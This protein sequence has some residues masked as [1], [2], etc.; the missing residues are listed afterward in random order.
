MTINIAA[1]E[2]LLAAHPLQSRD[3]SRSLADLEFWCANKTLHNKV[4]EYWNEGCCLTHAVGLPRHPATG[5]EMP[6]TDYQMDFFNHIASG[7]EGGEIDQP[8]KYH[9]NKARQMGFTEIV[10][11]TIQYGCINWY[12]GRNVGIVAATNGDLARK[13]MRR[14]TRLFRNIPW[15]VNKVVYSRTVD[16]ANGT[17]VEAFPASEEAMTGD[18]NYGAIFMDEAAKWRLVN[19]EPV[20]NSILPIVNTSASDLFLVSTPKGPSKMFYEIHKNPKDFK[21][22]KY[23][24]WESEGQLYDRK[25]IQ[26]MI[27]M[28]RESPDQE[29]LCRFVV[30]SDAAF[31]P[32][33]DDMRDDTGEWLGGSEDDHYVEPNEE[34][35]R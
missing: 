20:F 7:H 31:A 5:K 30:G 26:Y 27:K 13:D 17:R 32:V 12:T 10:L 35:S 19:D 8:H 24:I 21:K 6:L 11:R 15:M 3:G 4:E 18:T 25:K 9:V 22:L 2:K 16:L 14:F 23:D 29:Y 34:W 28:A 33:T 1:L